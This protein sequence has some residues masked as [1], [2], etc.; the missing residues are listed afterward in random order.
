MRGL[1]K[2]NMISLHAK[3]DALYPWLFVVTAFIAA[4]TLWSKV[5]RRAIDGIISRSQATSFDA[6]LCLCFTALA[7]FVLGWRVCMACR[8]RPLAAVCDE[9]LPDITVVIPAYNEGRQVLDT[10]RSVMSSSYPARKMQVI[11]VDDGSADDTWEWMLQARQEFPQR[12]LLIRQHANSGK[13]Q[14]LMAGFRR[15]AGSV[16]VTIDSDS[17]VQPDTLRHLVSPLVGNPR[18]GSV[19]GNVR[20]LNHSDGCIPKM[21]E[22]FFTMGFDFIRSGQSTYGG[23]FCT[24][25]ALSAYRASVIRGHLPAWARQTFRHSPA[26]IGEDRALTNIVLAS[27]YRVVYQREAVVFTKVPSTYHGLRA[28]LTRWARSNVRE[29][30]VMATF[31]L[32]PFR[33]GDGGGG[34]I[35]FFGILQLFRLAAGEALK[36]AL[37]VQLF[38]RPLVTLSTLAI[39]C[40]V[41]ATG[42][43]IVY[44]IRYRSWFGWCWSAPYCF[45]WLFGLTWISFWGLFSATQSGWLTRGLTGPAKHRIAPSLN[46]RL[47]E[48]EGSE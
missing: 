24:P 44:Q 23:V 45:F 12:L 19:A 20:V 26:T 1:I 8:Y 21:M 18:V 39:G 32:R 42:P 48:G 6:G 47:L 17:E 28:M 27:G 37:L 29:S 5:A 31:I 14:A 46:C 41:R 4:V 35:R 9:L 2:D 15:A 40:V 34:W 11:C 43:A 3:A 30:L 13:R 33:K 36:I 25:G 10:V 22:I 38:G 16:Y 7:L